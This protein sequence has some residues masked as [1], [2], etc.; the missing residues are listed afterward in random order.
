MRTFYRFLARAWLLGLVCLPALGRAANLTTTNVQGATADWTFAIWQTNGSGVAVAPVA[1]NTYRCVSNGVPFGNNKNNTR[2]RN[3]AA[4][5]L[6]TFPGDSLT[7]N[8]N[9][10]LRLKTPGAILN[11]PGVGGGPGLVLNGGVLNAG[12]ETVFVLTGKIQVASQSYFSAGNSGGG[13]AMPLRGIN[14]AAHLSGA[15]NFVF[16]QCTNFVA[17]QVSGISNTFSGQWIIKSGWLLASGLNSLGT[18][19]ITVDPSYV[20]PLDSSIVNVAGPASVEPGY[21]LNS[22]GK[23]IL[24]NGGVMVLHQNCIFSAVIIE[25]VALTSGIHSYADLAASFPAS[26]ASGGSGNLVVQ[27]YGAPP[28][29]PPA[30]TTQPLPV[31]LLVGSAAQLSATAS[32]PPSSY[33]WQKGT[34]GVYVNATN[35]GDLTGSRSNVLTFSALAYSDGADYRLIATNSV[36]KA[37]SQVATVTVLPPL[38]VA[39]VNPPAGSTVSNLTQVQVTF[40]RNVFGVDPADFLV[41]GQPA[42]SITPAISGGS[43]YTFTFTQPAPGSLSIGWDAGQGI[44]DAAGNPFNSTA[45]GSTWSYTLIDTIPPAISQLVP[46]PGATVSHLTQVQVSFTKPVVGVHASAF[47]I[48]GQPATNKTGSGS[49]PYLFQFPQPAT[50]TV[51]FAWAANNGITD[52]A[53]PPNPFA[54]GAWTITLNPAAGPPTVRI[55]EFLASNV[56][57]NG[58]VD[59]FG[60]LSPWLELYNFGTNDVNLAGYSLTDD[61]TAPDNWVFPPVSLP[62]GQFLIVFADGLDLKPGD[63]TP[64]HT[65]FA[66]TAAGAYLGLFD[67]ES[68]RVPLTEFAPAY[69]TQRNDYSYGYDNTNQLKYFSVPTPG[70]LNGFSSITG[71]VADVTF[72]VQRGFFNSRFSLLL[73]TPTPGATIRYT[74]DGS[75][76]TEI[77][78]GTTYTNALTI[79]HLAAVRAAAFASN[80]L[81]SL[82]QTHTYVFLTNVLNQPTNPPGFPISTGWSANG[83]PSEY[84][85]NQLIVTNPLYAAEIRNDLLAIP[86][87]SIAVKTD[88]MFGPTGIYTNSPA[89]TSRPEI[90]CSAE[91]I[92]PDGSPGFQVDCGIKIHGG[93]SAQRPMKK[94]LALKFKSSFGPGALNFQFFPDSPVKKFDGGFVLRADYNNHWTHALTPYG[95][96]SISQRAR[97]GLVRDPFYKDLQLAMGDLGSHSR[98]VHLYINGLYWGVYNPCEDPDRHFAAAYLGGSP[99]DYDSIKGS[100]SQLKVDGDTNAYSILMSFNNA[101]LATLSQYNQLQQYLDVPQYADYMLLQFY[102]ANQDWGPQQNWVAVHNKN[103]P[104]ALWEYLCWD[105]ERTLEGINDTPVGSP[106]NNVSPGNLQTNLVRNPEYRLLFADRAY[107]FLFH[108][109]VLTTNG[110]VPVWQARA[111]QIAQAIVGESARWGNSV[112]G[113]KLPMA[114]L[115][116]PSYDTNVPY[117]SRNENWL[118]E[119]A[120]LLTNYFPFRTAVVLSQLRA[121]GLYPAVDAPVFNQFGGHVPFGFNLTMT[122]PAGAIYYTTNGADPRVYGTGAVSPQALVYSNALTLNISTVI[123]ARALSGGTWS[124]LAESTFAV[125]ALEVPLCISEI[126]YN[127]PGGDACEFLEIENIGAVPLDV[128]SFSFQGINFIFPSGTVIQPGAVVVLANNASPSAWAARYPGVVVFGY[129]GGN[130]NNGGERIALL[131]RNGQTITAVTYDNGN[132]W[133]KQADGGGYSLEVIDPYGDPN[134]PANWRASTFPNGTP[135]LPPV[136]PPLANVLLNELMAANETTVPN[137]TN[138]PDW[139]ELYNRS[140]NAVSLANWSLSNSGNTRKFLFPT[141]TTLA[142]G[143]YLVVWCDSS[144]NDPGLHAGFNLSKSGDN[145]FLFDTNTNRVDAVSFGRQITDVSLG[146]VNGQWQLTLPTPN[147]PNLAATLG[148]QTNLALNEWLANPAPGGTNW[149]ELYNRSSNA[150]VALRG[151]YFAATNSLFQFRSLS[152]LPANAFLQLFADQAPGP[153]HVDLTMPASGSPLVLYDNTGVEFEHVT[154]SAQALGVSQ[155]RFPDGAPTFYSMPITT[156]GDP[157]VIPNNPPVLNPISNRFVHLGQTL[158]LTA[159]ATDPDSWYQTLTFTLTNSPAGAAIAPLTGAFSWTVANIAAPT[160]NAVTVCVTD[161]GVPPMS[162]TKTFLVFAQPPPQLGSV[163]SDTSGRI[164]F[165]FNSWPGESYQLQCKNGLS[166]PQWLPLGAA[167]LGTGGILALTDAT[168]TQHQRFY[169]LLVTAQ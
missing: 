19:S 111:S 160:T 126:M 167:V 113:G 155:G 43:N 64:L 100:D 149:I 1:G 156:P 124:A 10:E 71:V 25:G 29:F 46:A 77:T 146:R 161:N 73:T 87:L 90:A 16:T 6:L 104:G 58:L 31:T 49:G 106:L 68:P 139:T 48:N 28:A 8:T 67:D 12:D 14:F 121:V 37:T 32:G 35:V 103:L 127:P 153:T 75:Q 53:S 145:L 130:L 85:M 39:A 98:Y 59:Q 11:F 91:L 118:G 81:P 92:N 140:S 143:G 164:T 33:Q 36:G 165:S 169:R 17:Q 137:G 123:R 157:N 158:Q 99:D 151:L 117:Y 2:I 4:A 133:P 78:T 42:A 94:P 13:A 41:N 125:A 52:T 62:A 132:G 95:S 24:T 83:W 107:K 136:P 27:P 20:L 166:D 26:F 96:A 47:L 141:N 119:Q 38:A 23:L 152:F 115:P 45:P 51:Q 116:Y 74:T 18:N 44:S 134:A 30:F 9:T 86:T 60:N 3:P 150:P 57:T 147:A 129:Y 148:A 63:G 144:T 135:G 82:V 40:N 114:P 168:T 131:D 66:L 76:P 88:E 84:G 70:T 22:A 162:D 65:S 89:Q 56:S 154:S 110:I 105:D 80:S 34:N 79:D 5:G 120:R 142:A 7:L 61:P 72:S 50:G 138:F 112:P 159:I 122:A 69:P 163:R 21:D 109:G 15:G 55:N 108:N 101:G 102:G 93:G 128:S 97:G 54:G